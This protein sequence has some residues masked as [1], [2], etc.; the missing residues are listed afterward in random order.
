MSPALVGYHAIEE[1]LRAKVKN[2]VL[3]V[4][5]ANRRITSLVAQAR[6]IPI[7]VKSVSHREM[8]LL[9]ASD[10]HRGIALLILEAQQRRSSLNS[11]LTESS[12][13]SRLVLLLDGITDPQNLGALLRSAD[14]FSVDL[15]VLPER[16]SAHPNPTVAKTSAGASNYI[17]WI[18]VPN[19]VRSV[20]TLKKAGYWIYGA[21][22]KGKP[23]AECSFEG[24]VALA[25]G[26][27][28]RGLSRLMQESCDTIVSIPTAGHIDSLNVSVAG[29]ILLYEVRRQLNRR[30]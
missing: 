9:T 24:L 7:T 2:A 13:P 10:Q 22:I 8:D 27:E 6:G 30:D 14:L 29:G 21:D 20:E 19:L 5:G 1:A 4:S 17:Q 15:V 12:A 23:P 11:F 3:Y 28:G 16:R 18:S 26:S 25:L